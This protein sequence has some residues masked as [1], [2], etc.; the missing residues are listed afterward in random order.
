[1]LGLFVHFFRHNPIQIYSVLSP[2]LHFQRQWTLTCF[3]TLRPWK[4]SYQIGRLRTWSCVPRAKPSWLLEGVPACWGF[5]GK[6]W[7]WAWLLP[8]PGNKDPFLGVFCP[9]EL[10]WPLEGVRIR[11]VGL[12]RV[13]RKFWYQN[14]VVKGVSLFTSLQEISS[15][16]KARVLCRGEAPG[17]WYPMAVGWRWA[18]PV[19][20]VQFA[21]SPFY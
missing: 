10:S 4:A 9:T 13:Q 14:S 17:L 12:G 1:V 20:R 16:C 15:C 7:R 3:C 19:P 11:L 18:W 2:F 5:G 21:E 6:W 8:F